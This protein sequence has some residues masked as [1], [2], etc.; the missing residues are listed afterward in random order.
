MTKLPKLG[1]LQMQLIAALIPI[2]AACATQT[3]IAETNTPPASACAAFSRI[4]FD[5][6][7]DTDDTIKQV[8]AYDAARDAL[9]GKGN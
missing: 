6:L 2:L 5:R 3:P 9:C 8:K 4:T 1:L 7:K